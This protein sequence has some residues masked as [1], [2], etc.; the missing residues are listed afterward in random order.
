MS[1]VRARNFT[2]SYPGAE[3]HALDGVS[4][5]IGRGE[6]FGITGP[7]GAG[8]TTL[9][10]AIAGFAPRIMGGQASGEL[11]V[12]DFDPRGGPRGAN[13]GRVGMVFE[14]YVGQLTQLKA[15]DEVTTALINHGV[16]ESEARARA[17]ALL[18]RVGLCS[19]GVEDRPVW[20]L[21]GGQQQRLAIAATLAMD[22]QVLIL[23]SVMDKLDPSGQEKMRGLIA[24]L[25]GE[26]TLVLVNQDADLLSQT[27]DR[28]LILVN[29][30]VA[31]EGTPEELL[32]DDD[33]LARADHR[34]PRELACGSHSGPLWITAHAWR[35]RAG[36]RPCRA[37]QDSTASR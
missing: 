3:E 13:A 17:R 21:S 29:G 27:V 5:E 4:F 30:R 28:L 16:T 6:T 22:P 25:S 31:A 23:D 10:M 11:E 9:C 24:D 20:E 34:T 33:L 2:F 8:K 37:G 19:E 36:G 35:V 18:D 15:L 14:D 32:R 26:Q 7:V 12:A 1:M